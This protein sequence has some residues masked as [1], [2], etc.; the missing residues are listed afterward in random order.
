MN[1]PFQ[2]TEERA[3]RIAYL[4]AGFINKT[5]TTKEHD[6]LDLWLEENDE[7]VELFS[8]LTDERNVNYAMAFMKGI[9]KESAYEKLRSKIFAEKKQRRWL[10]PVSIAAIFLIAFSIDW[11]VKTK[12]VVSTLPTPDIATTSDVPPGSSKAVLQLANGKTIA[13][14]KDSHGTIAKEENIAIAADNQTLVYSGQTS[15]NAA[16]FNTL[17][18]PKGGKYKLVLS[19]GSQVWLN[20]ASSIKYPVAFNGPERSVVI[21]GEAFFD[22]TK[23]DQHPF[24]VQTNSAS[25]Q[26]LGTSFNVSSYL[27]EPLATA[28]LV[29]GKIKVIAA[30]KQQELA[31]G[32]QATIATT[33]DMKLSTANIKVATAWKDD[34]FVF[35]DAP[36]EQ[37]MR[38]LSRWY[39]VTVVYKGTVNYHF[40]AAISRDEPL[41]KVLQLLE[42]TKHVHFTLHSDTIEV[43]D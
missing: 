18:V 13:L 11:L 20:A 38:Q 26:V 25:I 17:T 42:Q 6:E 23:D 21:E 32:E 24:I 37:I 33:G 29:T 1:Y 19:D 31:P 30:G 4:V 43:S 27:D 39:N 36:I 22:V 2:E 7:N 40:F 14:G 41:S 35:K 3:Q 28:V 34:Q 15:S 10:L 5:L 12:P 8:R 9:D 16:V